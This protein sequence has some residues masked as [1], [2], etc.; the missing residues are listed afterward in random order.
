MKA[1]IKFEWRQLHEP[2]NH[3]DPAYVIANA[4][5]AAGYSVAESAQVQGV[6]DE[7]KPARVGGPWDETR[8]PHE[9]VIKDLQNR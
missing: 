3:Q 8:L 1:S 9:D 5:R 6:W 4:L 2:D 7:D